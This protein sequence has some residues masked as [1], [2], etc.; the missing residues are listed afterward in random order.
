L[1]LSAR[2]AS[3]GGGPGKTSGTNTTSLR[4]GGGG[5]DAAEGPG[6]RAGS[7]EVV[8]GVPPDALV[9]AALTVSPTGETP[10]V[11]DVEIDVEAVLGA[12]GANLDVTPGVGAAVEE[13]AGPED[14]E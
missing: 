10:V 2:T 8:A 1:L 4:G 11:A 5:G 6:S 13:D 9:R 12:G 3:A 7:E 14:D